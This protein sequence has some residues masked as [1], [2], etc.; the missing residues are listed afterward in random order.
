MPCAV[1]GDTTWQD[2][3]TLSDKSPQAP[4]IFVIDKLC[5]FA[6]ERAISAPWS[7][8]TPFAL[9]GHPLPLPPEGRRDEQP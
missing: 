7:V 8:T 3:A 5:L 4:D 1:P 2:L 9:N 6:A